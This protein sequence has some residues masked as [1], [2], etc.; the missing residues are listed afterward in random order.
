MVRLFFSDLFLAEF[1]R[2]I[3][4]YVLS[5]KLVILHKDEILIHLR[6]FLLT[7]DELSAGP[8]LEYVFHNNYFP[9][10]LSALSCDL[11]DDFY[12]YF[13]EFFEII[14]NI[15]VKDNQEA[16][17]L[18]FAFNCLS[19]LIYFLH[20]FISKDINNF[21]QLYVPLLTHKKEYIRSFS[22][23]SMAF[24]MRKIPSRKLFSLLWRLNQEQELITYNS[25]GTI[26]AEILSSPNGGF[27][28]SS[29]EVMR[30]VFA[31]S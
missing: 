12:P 27:H 7:S 30:N 8:I 23:Q 3:A 28:S 2:L 26:L 20:R 11:R 6:D 18:N 24:V 13:G 5:L 10:L 31:N 16:E 21:L 19:H 1:R 22:A 9:S 15:I 14:K 29:V 4:P 25:C 17:V